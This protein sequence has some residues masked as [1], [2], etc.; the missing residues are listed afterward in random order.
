MI[1][2]KNITH[3]LSRSTFLKKGL[4]ISITVWLLTGIANAQEVTGLSGWNIFLDPG[5]SR[6]ENMGL[7]NYSEAEKVLQVGHFLR[8]M[9][10][11]QTDIDTVYMSRTNQ[12]Q[13]V[14]LAQRTDLANRL[15]AD[16]YHSIHSNA[17]PASTNNTLML[18]GGW[19]LNNQIV[20]KTPEGGELM[21]DLMIQ[22]LT[23][24]MRIPTIGNY[25][26]RTFY[27]RD[28]TNP[29]QF[30]SDGRSHTRQ[31]PYLHVNRESQMASLLSEAG[32]HTSPTQQQRNIN[33]EWKKLEA[34][35]HFWSILSY[36]DAEHPSVGILTGIVSDLDTSTPINGA[37]IE[38][39]GQEYTTDTYESKFFRHSTDPE[40]LSNGFYYI[41]NL[42]NEELEV[43]ISAD[44]YYSNTTNISILNNDFTFSDIQLL[45]SKAPVINSISI[46][47]EKD[48]KAGEP[49]FV[50]FSRGMDRES[51]VQAIEFT[52][53]VDS[54]QVNWN[55]DS[56]MRIETSTLSFLSDYTLRIKDTAHD[57]S[58]YK[59]MLDGDNDGEMGGDYIIAF[60]TAAE[61]TDPP[62]LL[63][64]VFPINDRQHDLQPIASLSFDEKLD[65][66]SI[67]SS[68]IQYLLQGVP[69]QGVTEYY[70]IGE[71]SVLNFFPLEQLIPNRNYFLLVASGISDT[72]GNRTS[73]RI[74]RTF[75]T[76]NQSI[77]STLSIDSFEEGTSGWWQPSQ[78]GSTTGYT[79]EI[80][81][82]TADTS[83][84]NHLTSSTGSL[85]LTYGWNTN[86][87][88]HLIR[89][90]RPA[91]SPKFSSNGT[92]QVYLFGDGSGNSFRFMIRDGQNQLEGSSWIEIDWYG[93]RLVSWDMSEDEIVP[94][95]NGNGVI[96]GNGY[97]D[98]FQL[99]YTGEASEG[100]LNFDDLR[101]VTFETAVSTDDQ[102]WIDLPEH[103]TLYPNYPNPFN[104]STT[105]RFSLPSSE[106]VQ[107]SVFDLMGRKVTEHTLGVLSAGTHV[108]SF[109]ATDISSG[110]YIY[111]ISTSAGFVSGKMSLIK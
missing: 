12:N 79:P 62:K 28:R 71:Y 18:H 27:H 50:N 75:P 91:T 16:F 36:M 66:S 25:A 73:S 97:L 8:E 45:S 13:S 1:H 63:T 81:L 69:V 64:E 40:E 104:P 60:K 80:T 14:S 83:R 3:L 2:S 43:K 54:I 55:S 22:D 98:S 34:Q 6:T 84:V 111:R 89:L 107:F 35:S 21:G 109:D 52:P 65:L 82:Q 74:I 78:S 47:P 76:T 5:H 57:Q 31:Y 17:G 33:T 67:D 4:S 59:H 41:E 100:T 30:S 102:D 58:E 88:E 90:Y 23:A 15:A 11:T 7:Y 103:L 105:I 96:T 24:A 37:K 85:K 20:E 9:L 93:W 38:V 70:E 106:T 26:D 29:D 10:L 87:S 61:D 53:S 94:W 95:V 44:G 19:Y 49:I 77:Q 46:Q 42:P 51:V 72:L 86:D 39:N 32:F 110:H 92:L 48:V 68:T 99:T 108:Y 56:E 101:F